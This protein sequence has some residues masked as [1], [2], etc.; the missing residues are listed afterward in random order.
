MTSST[1]GLIVEILL[2]AIGLYLYLFARGIISFGSDEAKARAEAFRKDNST[3][4]RLMGLALAA[5]MAMN[6][7]FHVKEM[8]G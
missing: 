3:W 8:M 1:A 6:V 5:V 2:F 7:F 4:M